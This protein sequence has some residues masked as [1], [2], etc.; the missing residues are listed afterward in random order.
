MRFDNITKLKL[1]FFFRSFFFFSPI[2]TLFYFSRNLDTF[3]IVSLEAILIGAVLLTEVPTGILADKIGRKYSLTMVILLFII[4]NVWTIYAH[5]YI[6]FFV[7]EV[8]FGVGIA[9]GSGA[10]EALVYDSLKSKGKEKRMS[11]IWG[12]IN[13][14]ALFASVVAVTV[15]GFLAR[16]HDPET[17][18][19]LLWLYTLGAVIAFII[20]LTVKEP[21]PQKK[22]ARE[23]PLTLFKRSTSHILKNKALRKIIL[24]S[25][26]TAPFGHIIMFLF[27]PYFLMANVENSMWGLIMAAGILLG[28][29]LMRYA[30]KIEKLFGMRWTILIATIIPGIMYIAMAFIIGPIYSFIWYIIHSGVSRMREPLFS[31]YQNAHI[32]SRNR[33]TVL[34]VISMIVSMYLLVMRLVMGKIADNSLILSFIVMGTIIVVGALLFRIDERST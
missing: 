7:I 9:F 29:L 19:S 6:E 24:L 16:S 1:I 4:G 22:I 2:L 3:Q 18:V 25:V 30:Y 17:F 5:S 15:G 8:L 10:V 11:K 23:N 33:A 13:S 34:S 12:S 27:Q 26:F 28:A 14:Y 20:S 31:Q 32:Q 21:R